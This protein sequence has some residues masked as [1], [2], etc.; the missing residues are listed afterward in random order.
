MEG[1]CSLLFQL[2]AV[3]FHGAITLPPILIDLDKDFEVNALAKEL[4][5]A[6]AG[7]AADA[8][9]GYSLM[10]Y[11]DAFLTVALH[12]D[13]GIDV[14]VLVC[15][16]EL[17]NNNLYAVGYL[18]VVIKQ[19][20]LADNLGYEEAGRLIGPLVLIEVSRALGQE[21]LYALQHNINIE[22]VQGA[23]GDNLCLG[24][25]SMPL[26]YYIG[27]LLLTSPLALRR[28]VRGEAV[29][30]I[31]KNQNGASHTL[32]FLQELGI[33][34]GCLDH[35]GYIEQNIG[36]LK[37]ALA[38]LQHLFLKFVVGLQYTWCVRETYLHLGR[39]EDTHDAVARGLCLEGGNT[40]ALAHQKVHER[41]LTHIGVT[42]YVYKS[43]FMHSDYELRIEG[44]Q[45]QLR[46]ENSSLSTLN[47]TNCL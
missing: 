16:L 21:F 43:C 39:I 13:N 14:D 10:A 31:D 9:Q 5:Q 8:L 7:F 36:I 3:G 47:F 23:D 24:Q 29:N 35:I 1:S 34:V 22:L 12:V 2:I 42:D 15:F 6:L 37:G 18:L 45:R 11:D 17:F 41:A 25:Y 32:D 40:D 4:L 28:G 30:L 38:E 20:L 44:A 33:L 19:Y 26:L 46:I 27:K